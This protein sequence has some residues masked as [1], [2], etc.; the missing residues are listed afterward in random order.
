M[1]YKLFL[2]IVVLATVPFVMCGPVTG[3]GE[4]FNIDFIVF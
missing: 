2:T 1:K 3:V 4:V